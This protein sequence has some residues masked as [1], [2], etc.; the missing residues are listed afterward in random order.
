MP[1]PSDEAAA[2][3]LKLLNAIRVMQEGLVER[4]TEVWRY[5]YCVPCGGAAPAPTHLTIDI[6]ELGMPRSF[7]MP[8]TCSRGPC[9]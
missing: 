9:H 2:I 6:L 1:A 7:G 4:D 8:M 3:R 5:C